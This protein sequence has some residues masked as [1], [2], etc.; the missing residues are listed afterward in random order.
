MAGVR[1]IRLGE[2]HAME[3]GVHCPECG[4][5]TSFGDV[6]ATARCSGYERESCDVAMR[7]ELLVE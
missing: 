7:L 3:G 4:S 5:Y 6:L 2:Q 1:R